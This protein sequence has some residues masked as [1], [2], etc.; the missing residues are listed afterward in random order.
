MTHSPSTRRSDTPLL[1]AAAARRGRLHFS[2]PRFTPLIEA[3]GLLLAAANRA[4]DQSSLAHL[5]LL[6]L[7]A[8]A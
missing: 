6:L 7:D 3:A 4:A 1:D 2:T 5:L 8:A